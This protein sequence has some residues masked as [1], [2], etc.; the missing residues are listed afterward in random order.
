[1]QLSGLVLAVAFAVGVV[2]QD[3]KLSEVDGYSSTNCRNYVESWVTTAG[4]TVSEDG[5]CFNFP[6]NGYPSVKVYQLASSRGCAGELK[7]FKPL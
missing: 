1:M 3:N 2:A 7:A 6:G 5:Q 4:S